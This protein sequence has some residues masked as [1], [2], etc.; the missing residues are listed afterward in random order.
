VELHL[1]QSEN[2]TWTEV[3]KMKGDIDYRRL[4]DQLN[5]W[6]IQPHWVLEQAV[7]AASPQTMDAV[8]AHRQSYLHLERAIL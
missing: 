3:F 8:E 2:G 4:F 1:R 7:E 5:A 6:N